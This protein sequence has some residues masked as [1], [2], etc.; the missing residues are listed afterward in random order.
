MVQNGDRMAR[1]EAC[2]VV[3]A[4]RGGDID[5][6]QSWS[7]APQRRRLTAAVMSNC[8]DSRCSVLRFDLFQRVGGAKS[9]SPFHGTRRGFV[10]THSD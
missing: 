10:I 6:D 9:R 3:Y 7:G 2:I 1:R 8:F 4:D 5:V